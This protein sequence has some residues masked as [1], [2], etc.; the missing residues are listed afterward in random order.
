MGGIYLL[1]DF[2]DVWEKGSASTDES[3]EPIDGMNDG[4]F[5]REG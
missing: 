2:E 5:E 4:G 1:D 3:D